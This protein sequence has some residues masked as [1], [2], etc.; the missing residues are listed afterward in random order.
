MLSY[1]CW[2]LDFSTASSR[3]LL[4]SPPPLFLPPASVPAPERKKKL[5]R[6]PARKSPVSETT[7]S[8]ASRAPSLSDS[9]SLLLQFRQA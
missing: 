2:A 1:E 8:T 9:P 4:L 3:A 5:P 6:V 7:T